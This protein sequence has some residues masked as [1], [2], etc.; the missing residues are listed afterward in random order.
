MPITFCSGNVSE[1][2][3]RRLKK[4]KDDDIKIDLSDS[5]CK[6]AEGSFGCSS[7]EC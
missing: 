4:G 1:Y 3:F 5:G 2:P 6:H 7:V